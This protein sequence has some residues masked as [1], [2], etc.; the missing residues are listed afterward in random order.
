MKKNELGRVYGFDPQIYPR[1]IWVALGGDEGTLRA[2]FQQNDGKQL[3][4]A[5]MDRF[6]ANTTA[7]QQIDTGLLGELIWFP[8]KS[9]MRFD[10][11]A[12]E[13]THA[14]MDIFGDIGIVPDVNNQEPLAYLVGWISDCIDKVKRGKI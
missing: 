6:V 1:R 14:A 4:F 10:Y 12:H 7:V 2:S 8:K 5:D 11:I 3:E 9:D 13:A